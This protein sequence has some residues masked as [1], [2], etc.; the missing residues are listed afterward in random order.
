MFQLKGGLYM[1][2]LI[3]A[4]RNAAALIGGVTLYSACNI[5][6][7]DKIAT[8]RNISEEEKLRWKNKTMLIVDEI[9]QVGGLTLASVDSYLRLYRDDAY[10][11][12][13]GIS[14]VIFFGDFFQFEPVRQTSLLL[15]EPREHNRQRLESLAKHIAAYKLFLQFT[16]VI[17]LREQVRTAGCARLC[18]FLWRLRNR[19]QTELDFQQL[20]RRL[21][22]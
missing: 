2:L 5:G 8:T 15:P 18:G 7:E 14:V 1:L 20:Y 16:T 3:G 19:E 22:N 17:M 13:G 11:P 9:S 12:F 10:R 21:Y 4:S 6:F